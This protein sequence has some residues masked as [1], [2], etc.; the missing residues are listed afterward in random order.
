[1]DAHDRG[2]VIRRTGE[3]ARELRLPHAIAERARLSLELGED[4]L[5]VLSG[6]KLEQLDGVTD[7]LGQ[8]ARELD[9]FREPRAL[10][11]DRLGLGLVFPK[12]RFAR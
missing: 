4:C 7:V 6:G 12:V 3:H 2:G 10:P 11:Q 5:V 1:M 8:R 9:L